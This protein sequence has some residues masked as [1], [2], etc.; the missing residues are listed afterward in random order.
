[1]VGFKPTRT[2]E[3]PSPQADEPAQA[4]VGGV[5]LLTTQAP[6]FALLDSAATARTPRKIVR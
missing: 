1:M 4:P 6:L 2:N 5:A 3:E